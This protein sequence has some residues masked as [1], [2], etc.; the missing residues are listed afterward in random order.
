MENDTIASKH[1]ISWVYRPP[2]ALVDA[3]THFIDEFSCYL[4]D[5]QKIYRNAYICGDININVLTINE[6]NKYNTFYESIISSH[7]WF[8]ASNYSTHTLIRYLWN[9]IDNI[10][11]NKF[12][13][14]HKNC[15]LTRIISD[16]QMTCC[17]L[18]NH[19][20]VKWVDRAY[21]EVVNINGKKL[22]QPKNEL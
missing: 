8:Y 14:I 9:V 10:F 5:V 17:V 6:N 1:L 21:I 16:L 22:G 12:E 15:I 11:T 7:K 19:N 18:L 20:A 3:L 4:G 2:T 13:K